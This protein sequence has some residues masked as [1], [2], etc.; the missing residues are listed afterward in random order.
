M[1]SLIILIAEIIYLILDFIDNKKL[2][3]VLFLV[4]SLSGIFV[5]TK[6]VQHYW[7]NKAG[8]NYDELKLPTICWLAYGM[9]YDPRNPGHYTNQFEVFHVEMVIR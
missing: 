2:L 7:E 4:L 8:V 5:G 3:V 9:N 6:G 1:N